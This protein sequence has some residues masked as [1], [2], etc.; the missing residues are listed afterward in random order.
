MQIQKSMSTKVAGTHP[1][2][3]SGERA[4]VRFWGYAGG[5]VLLGGII[6]AFVGGWYW[7]PIG[8]VLAFIMDAANS[9]TAQHFIAE[10]ARRDAK[11]KSEMV[12]AGVISGD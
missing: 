6:Y 3:P 9:R 10:A 8:I 7:A 2:I 12:S 1:A 5:I 11:F 4:A